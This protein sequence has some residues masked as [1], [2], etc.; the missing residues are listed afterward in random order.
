MSN[1]LFEGKT[2]TV[3]KDHLLE[4][5]SDSKR[6]NLD[7]V[8]ENYRR[9]VI[10]ENAA[11]GVTAAGN[12]ASINKLMLPL[13][14]RVMPT[15]IA[16]E[17]VGVQAMTG[18]IHQISTLRTRYA[19]ASPDFAAGTEALGPYDIAKAYSGNN[20]ANASTAPYPS[21][22]PTSVL[23]GVRGNKLSIQIVKDT[24][25]AQ[26]RRLSAEWT[27]EGA[28]DANSQYGVD[29]EAE[30]MQT[31]ATEM[32]VEIDQEIL[33]KL[34][35][36]AGAATMTYD[37]S[38]VSGTATFVGDEHAALS[39][40]INYQANQIAARTRRGA[41]NWAVVS[42]NALTVLQ[43][44]TTSSFARTTEGVFEAPTNVK[45][46]GVLNNSMRIYVDTYA[47]DTDGVLLGLKKSDQ[48]AAAYYCP[49]IPMMG[50]GPIIHPDT[51]TMVYGV[52]SRYGFKILDNA[53]SSFANGKDHLAKIAINAGTLTFF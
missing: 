35:G 2:W 50:V 48:E 46:A 24:V 6:K 45:F 1:N 7:I 10:R 43:S 53:A 20:V 9:E 13:M 40:M 38:A 33:G 39:V 14:R 47:S 21:A 27:M 15:V 11:A 37:Q 19:D 18:P 41:A 32:I 49:Y 34:R 51:F 23:E 8:M 25:E 17:L 3:T 4:G 52:K 42:N 31:L 29:L 22:A 30:L 12:I 36:L 28:Q 16:N 5:L 26:T 44:A